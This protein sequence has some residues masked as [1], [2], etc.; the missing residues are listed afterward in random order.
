MSVTVEQLELEVQSNSTAAVSGIDKLASSLNTLKS[1][2]K[3]GA[4]LSAISKQIT[5]LNNSLNSFSGANADRM[6][7]LVSGLKALSS[8]GQVKISSSI[9]NQ[10]T[11]IGT[12]VRSLAGADFS[13]LQSLSTSLSTLSAVGKSNLDGFVTP[14]QRLPQALSALS[15]ANIGA[16]SV[17]IKELVS[18][19]SPLTQIGKNQLASFINQ[20]QKLPQTMQALRS[21]NI[22]ELARQIEQLAQAFSPLA[23]EMQSISNGFSALPSKLQK[24]ISSTN[25][26]SNANDKSASSY[27]SLAGKLSAF[28]VSVTQIGSKI[29]GLIKSSNQ[30]IEDMNLFSVSMGSFASEAYDYAQQVGDIMGIDPGEWMRNQGVFM[31]ITEGFGVAS[32]RAYTMSKNLTQLTYDLS[33]F[34]NISTEDAFQKLESGIAGELEPLRRLGYDLSVAR[35]QQEAYALGI[36]KSVNEMTQAEKAELRYHAIMTQVTSAQ[37]DMARTLDDPAN[38]LRVLRAQL[39]QTARA[40]GN[41]FLPILKAVLP[42]L[43]AFA[44]AARQVAEIIADFF[45]I[46]LPEVDFDENASEGVADNAGQIAGSLEDASEK[47]AELKSALLGIDELNIISPTENVDISTDTDVG[48]GLGFDLVEYDFIT[49]AINDSVDKIMNKIN[50]FIEGIKNNIDEILAGVLAIGSA[51]LTWKIAKGVTEVLKY[52]SQIG[53]LNISF[54]ITGLGLFLDAWNTLKDAIQDILE[55]GVNFTNVT[56]LISGFAEGLGAAF[57]SFGNIKIGSAMLII[58]SISGFI[59]ACSDIFN[60]GINWENGTLLAKNIGMFLT[61]LG[62]LRS[63]P[64]LTGI[65]LMITGA[66]LIVGNIKGLIEAIKTGDWSNVDVIEIATGALLTIG[67]FILALKKLDDTAKSS[68]DVG[69]AATETIETVGKTTSTLFSKLKNLAKDLGMG[70]IIIGEVSLAASMIVGEIIILGKG[71]EEIGKAWE[72]IGDMGDTIAEAMVLGVATLA[73]VGTTAA[74]L[75][76]AGGA[77]IAGNIG[78]GTGIIAEISLATD[79]FLAEILI[80]GKLLTEI[81]EAWQPVLDN[82]ETIATGIGIGT[83]LLVGIGVVTAL[84]GAA[85]VATAGALPLAIGLGTLMLVELAGAT[86]AFIESLVVVANALSN[87]LHPALKDLN[88]KLPEL[89]EDMS[90]FTDFMIKFAGEVVRYSAASSIS[91]LAG[92]IDT[93]VGWFTQDPIEKLTIEARKIAEQ[94]PDLVIELE[95]AVP[96]LESASELIDDYFEH[97]SKFSDNVIVYSAKSSIASLAGTIDTIIGWFTQDPFDKI[98]TEV[99]ETAAQVPALNAELEIAVPNLETATGLLSSYFDFMSDFSDEVVRYSGKSSVS[100]L[101]GTL[102]T[103]IGWFTKDPFEKLTEEV[104]KVADQAPDL[105]EELERAVPELEYVA[106]LLQDY[107]DFLKNIE[108]LTNTDVNLSDGTFANMKEVGENLVTGFVEGIESKSSEF[109]DAGENLV[110]GFKSAVDETADTCKRNMTAWASNLKTWFTSTAYGGITSSTFQSY[111]K[112]AV[113]GFNS[114]ITNSY[115]QS[116]SAIATWAHSIINWFNNIVSSNDFY[117]IARDTISGFN[118][119]INDSYSSSRTYMQR[120]ANDL[121]T[122]FKGELDSN[123]PSKLFEKIGDDTVLGYNLGVS[124]RSKTTKDVINTWV[125][126]FTDVTP[127]VGI[128]VDTST[129]KY[130]NSDAFTKPLSNDISNL[131]SF[132][133]HGFKEDMAEFYHDYMEPVMTQMADDMKRQADKNEQTIVQIGNRTVSDSVTTQRKANG[134]VFVK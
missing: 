47:A 24:L 106:G 37:K 100:S 91:A 23:K 38:Q 26:L 54:K 2:T 130:Y 70:L 108:T 42:Y 14:L 94:V 33:S 3:G 82:G 43:I 132:S 71:F 84:L 90:D 48:G 113:A 52:L 64:P 50:P 66:S 103:I 88:E 72:P 107:F 112:S 63:K 93:I 75:G 123:S 18:A 117:E 67:G 89:T 114:G 120:W 29:A 41:L 116:K 1:A 86:V 80:I 111:A 110:D 119:G 44:K 28:Y 31:T 17:Q 62:G 7:K 61:G 20:L 49:D 11:G 55:N 45:N 73:A 128:A 85:T 134:Y 57:L 101:S 74:G 25:N 59:S 78:I 46:S 40:F 9:A 104:G 129:L 102:D 30:Y 65:G 115:T 58:S 6:S 69:K 35:L 13:L 32:D 21:V 15:S 39:E 53:S 34:F 105:S 60:N 98:T 16:A 68:K 126:S 76:S 96:A 19:L 8:L 124:G 118:D 77:S 4:G 27:I 79:L 133:V 109:S 127:S 81:G 10:I 99:G 22:G 125:K 122:T 121:V 131:N 36:E 5:T 83:G 87:D 12:A 97:M 95:K 51:F 56:Q 92:T